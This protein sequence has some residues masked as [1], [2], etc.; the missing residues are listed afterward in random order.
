MCAHSNGEGFGVWILAFM[1]L[2]LQS[3]KYIRLVFGVTLNGSTR[4]R[5]SAFAIGESDVL[6]S[7]SGTGIYYHQA[8]NWW[9]NIPSINLQFSKSMRQ[10]NEMT[11]GLMSVAVVPIIH[12]NQYYYRT[13]CGFSCMRLKFRDF[14]CTAFLHFSEISAL[15]KYIQ[16]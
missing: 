5:F 13:W 12:G 8:S 3:V 6:N 4:V 9:P 1:Y 16:M 10:N 7:F 14:V 2:C 15:C 11:T